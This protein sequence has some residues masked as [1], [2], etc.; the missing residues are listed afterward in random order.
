MN[1]KRSG[2][3][4]AVAILAGAL[5]VSTGVRLEAA[6]IRPE[7]IQAWESYIKSEER[8]IAYELASD[9]KFLA[10]DFLDADEAAAE[11]REILGGEIAVNRI[12][13]KQ[14]GHEFEVPYGTIQHWRGSIFIPGVNMD[15][16]MVHVQDPEKEE[17]LQ[18]D[19]IESRVL[20]RGPDYYR[21]FF[22]LQRSYLVTVIYNTEHIVHFRRHGEMRASSNSI[23]TKIAEVERLDGNLEREKPVGEDRGFLWR[24]N[25][26]WRYQQTDG[27]VIIECESMTLS[28]SV[29]FII[30]PI[31]RP[32][33]NSIARDSMERT[34]LSL[35]ER[36]LRAAGRQP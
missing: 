32:I 13:I 3:L 4:K 30:A 28:R 1:P 20:E 17:H 12:D 36:L 34:L 24:M 11:K 15:F 29:P 9:N 31:A 6:D 21:I 26:Y 22:K 5:L 14:D 16:V 35:R 10:L 19:V 7:T 8:R 23:S 18:E 33:I 25:S 27:G 2:V